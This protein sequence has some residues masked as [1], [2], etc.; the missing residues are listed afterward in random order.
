MF[1]ASELPATAEKEKASSGNTVY[2]GF[3]MPG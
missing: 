2:N 3:G 1:S